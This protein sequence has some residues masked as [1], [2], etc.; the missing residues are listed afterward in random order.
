MTN[1]SVYL[2]SRLTAKDIFGYDFDRIILATGARWRRDGLSRWHTAPVEGF[3]SK[4]IFTPDDIMAGIGPGG[5][6]VIF[7]DDHYYMG[8]VLAEKLKMNGLEVT[9][10]TPAGTV[11]QWSSNTEEM[12]RTQRRLL[13]LGV[14]ILNGK[15][16][17]AFDGDTAELTC[18][19]TEKSFQQPAASLLTVTAR[20]PDDKLYRQLTY[21]PDALKESVINSIER[22][23]DCH[24]PG[25]IAAAV[26]AGHR[27]AREMDAPDAGDV[28][29]R[30]ERVTV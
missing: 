24:A 23:G 7:D 19:Y 1:V 21:D 8:A 16:V 22:I 11:G 14:K 4:Q 25:T 5:P 30:R 18:V 2:D 29:F 15:A 17:L 27:A 12:E 3:D 13:N 10:V 28:S 20:Q 9:L 26:Y 6:V